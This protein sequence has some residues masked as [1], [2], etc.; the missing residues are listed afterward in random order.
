MTVKCPHCGLEGKAEEEILNKKIRCPKCREIFI[1]VEAAAEPVTAAAI[2]QESDEQSMA[3]ET[4]TEQ[5]ADA[6]VDDSV[7]EA[8][9]ESSCHTELGE[10]IQEEDIALLEDEG[11]I[12]EEELPAGVFRC[13]CCGFVFSEQYRQ[14]TDQGPYCVACNRVAASEPITA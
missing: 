14:D 3:Q 10:T 12:Q 4:A 6:A 5:K 8:I 7:V 1:A 2:P 11:E 9:A 13:I